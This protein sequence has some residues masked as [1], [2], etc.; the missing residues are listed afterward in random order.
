M[1]DIDPTWF[2]SKVKVGAPD[3]CWP[4]TGEKNTRGG[5]GV[6]RYDGRKSTGAHR[7]AFMLATGEDPGDLDVLHSCDNPPCCN[8]GDL[9]AGTA[10]DNAR[11]AM[12]RNRVA[13]NT[14]LAPETV[15][16]I[17]KLYA[18]GL[19]SAVIGRQFGISQ[20][21]AH[22]LATG[23][24]QT[25]VDGEVAPPE[26]KTRGLKGPGM[27]L[28]DAQVDE[29]RALWAAGGITQREIGE[30]FGVSQPYVSTIVNNLDRRR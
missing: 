29:V 22:R 15:Q 28:T 19:S 30:R 17:R 11:D 26:W 7:V 3:E 1:L 12:E 13:R 27:K 24:S 16:Q 10:A 2:W 20:Q 14:K 6:V 25:V 23:R 9:R 5:Y 21:Q 8:P 4:W 18:G